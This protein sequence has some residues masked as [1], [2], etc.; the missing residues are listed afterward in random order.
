[1]A[2]KKMAIE[3]NK[4][5]MAFVD[6]VKYESFVEA[7][8]HRDMLPSL[9]SR[10][11]KALEDK[12]GVVLLKRTTRALSLTEAGEEIYQ[13]ALVLKGLEEKMN[14]YA[15]NY[16]TTT[17]GLVRLTCASHLSLDYVLPSIREIQSEYPDIKFEVDYDDRRVDIIKEEFDMA[18]RVWEPQDSSLIGQKLRSSNLVLVAS[19]AFIEKYGIPE[20]IEQLGELPSACYARHG[21][22]R[23][24]IR[25]YDEDKIQEVD[26]Q[27]AYKS[28]SPESLIQSAKAG[29]YYTMVT[30]HNATRELLSGELIQLFPETHFPDEAAIYAVYPN[31]ALSFGARLFIEKIKRQFES[32]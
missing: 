4:Q 20:T 17:K 9:L 19:P 32:H 1:M 26:M 25:F 3:L 15:Q 27:P 11:I 13:Q 14:S 28:S 18:I 2:S 7:A 22:V 16:S 24:K 30:D 29:M 8:K 5:L 21:V 23:D 31:R 6:V 10:N 12:L